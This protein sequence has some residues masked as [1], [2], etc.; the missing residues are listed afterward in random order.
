MLQTKVK[1]FASAISD[2]DGN[3]DLDNQINKWSIS[4]SARI[5]SISLTSVTKRVDAGPP[6]MHQSFDIPV[7][8]AAVLYDDKK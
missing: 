2:R 5:I 8:Y 7:L 4:E 6:G 3:D 1:I